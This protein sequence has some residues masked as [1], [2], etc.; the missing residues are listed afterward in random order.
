L[1]PDERQV[2]KIEQ[3]DTRMVTAD[4]VQVAGELGAL[5]DKEFSTQDLPECPPNAK[6]ASE[7]ISEAV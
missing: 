3:V 4:G 1:T 7:L 2:A 6:T 5:L